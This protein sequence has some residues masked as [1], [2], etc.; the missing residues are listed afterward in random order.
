MTRQC[1]PY[2]ATSLN[3]IV[4]LKDSQ[5]RYLVDGIG[6][7]AHT[8][9]NGPL[10]PADF[11]SNPP[12]RCWRNADALYNKRSTNKIKIA[13]TEMDVAINNTNQPVVQ[14]E[15]RDY[16]LGKQKDLFKAACAF[17]VNHPAAITFNIWGL[18][19]EYGWAG[20]KDVE[21][22]EPLVWFDDAHSGSDGTYDKKPAWYGLW[23]ALTGQ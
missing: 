12:G 22:V 15:Q 18:T 16:R 13:I 21:R 3:S 20:A 9:Y 1:R 7:Q 8:R 19:D 2:W 5:G 23:E 11:A 6:W 14:P 4:P 10:T 17:V